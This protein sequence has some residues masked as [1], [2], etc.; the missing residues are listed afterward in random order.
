MSYDRRAFEGL[1]DNRL[2]YVRAL[3]RNKGFEAGILRLLTQ[4]Y[5]DN[6]HFIYELLQNA[7]DAKAKHARFSVQPHGLLFEHDGS[8]LFSARDV[9]SIT[10]IGDSTKLESPTAIGKFGVGFKAVFAY[11][12]APEIHSGQYHFRIHDLVVPEALPSDRPLHGQFTTCFFF[13]FDHEKKPAV[14]AVSEVTAALRALDDATLLFLSNIGQISYTLPD[15][16]SGSLERV[17]GRDEQ[18]T[19]SS[20]EQIEVRVRKAG[21][22]PTKSSW[23]RYRKTVSVSDERVRKDCT[24]AI[25][26]SLRPSD[27]KGNKPGWMIAPLNPGRVSIYFPAEK[28]TSNLR[29]HL[30]APFASTVARDSV[31]ETPGNR[32]LLN[33]LA[34]LAADCMEDIRDRELLT[35]GFLEVLP[36]EDDSV[37]PFYRPIQDRLVE[38][39]NTRPLVPTR[40]GGH[41]KADDLLRGPS[42]IVSLISDADLNHLTEDQWTDV[43]W[44]ANAPQA[45][46]RADKF[47]DSLG[48]DKWGWDELCESIDCSEFRLS[49]DDDTER[50]ARLT[51]WLSTKDDG[52]LRRFYAV[53]HE[54]TDTHAN[55]LDVE[56]LALVRIEVDGVSRLV[57]PTEAFFPRSDEDPLPDD[58]LLVKPGTYLSGK[59]ETQKNAARRF[60]ESAGVKVFDEAADLG[61]LVATYDEQ[62]PPNLKAHLVHIKRFM[63]FY[64][65]QPSRLDVFD[66]RP[67]LVGQDTDGELQ[68]GNAT[69]LYLD[70][71]FEETG[72]SGTVAV[73]DKKALWDGYLKLTSQKSF[74]QFVRALGIQSDL[75]IV[76]TD[77]YGNPARGELRKDYHQGYRV[78][79]TDTAIDIDWTILGIAE[80]VLRPTL[81]GSRLL[82]TTMSRANPRVAIARFRPNRQYS[83]RQADSQLIHWLKNHAWV[84][85]AEGKFHL[86]KDI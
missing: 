15:G 86:P 55:I 83:T 77:T 51:N 65:A 21:T 73:G 50:P 42:N 84:P 81:D 28:E 26:F 9:E 35:V 59:S 2:A 6:A 34:D 69:D 56:G 13:P 74:V 8:R 3:R 31:R 20:G 64:K 79:W 85:D 27:T 37:P 10:S 76:E 58:V 48:I 78:R 19:G 38:A 24:V 17:L 46:Q 30:H 62:T 61:R 44:C 16:T 22:K 40:Y 82:W 52:W 41:R 23:L 66:G 39:F 57:K 5:P 47:L 7:E 4:L 33:F 75:P 25:A 1:R 29:F 53:L 80:F 60:L 45:N 43:A 54:A 49:Y 14:V 36:I 32:Q 71:P 63:E 12:R 70:A 11:T 72:L 68:W 18:G 67:I